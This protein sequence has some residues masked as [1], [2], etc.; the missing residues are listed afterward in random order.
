MGSVVDDRA[1]RQVW[2]EARAGGKAVEIV[3]SD[4]VDKEE[5]MLGRSYRITDAVLEELREAG[6]SEVALTSL[7]ALR[8]QSI[9]GKAFEQRLAALGPKKLDEAEIK[10]IRKYSQ[11]SLLR[12]ERFIPNRSLREWVDALVFAVVIAAVVRTFIIAPF[13]IPSA[14]ME[15]TIQVGDHIFA[16]MFSYGLPVPF[17]DV[18]IAPREIQRGDIVIFPFPADPSIDY[19]K[20]VVGRGGETVEMKG[21]QMYIDGK[22]L[23]E[24]YAF[25][26]PQVIRLRQLNGQQPQQFGPVK[27]PPGKLFVMGD[28]RFNSSDSRYWGFVDEASVKGKGWIIYFSHDP[29]EGWFDGYRLGRIAHVID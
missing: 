1:P 12:L 20:R 4:P 8:S 14:S 15:P 9:K 7:R 16:K 22:P 28:N 24:P 10:L 3:R 6:L 13:K 26:D 25:Y 23:S 18:R 21:D 11:L 5:A 19:I 29:E 2:P 17:T 27:V